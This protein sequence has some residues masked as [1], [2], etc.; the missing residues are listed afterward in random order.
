MY[1]HK[2]VV[3]F[4]H[5]VIDTEK[6]EEKKQKINNTNKNIWQWILWLDC[7]AMNHKYFYGHWKLWMYTLHLHTYILFGICVYLNDISLIYLYRWS[8]KIWK[9]FASSHFHVSQ[10]PNFHLTNLSRFKEWKKKNNKKNKTTY[11]NLVE[12]DAKN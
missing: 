6:E 5:Q 8:K 3:D 4:K 1:V 9:S 10:L 11:N 12:R 2:C 7:S